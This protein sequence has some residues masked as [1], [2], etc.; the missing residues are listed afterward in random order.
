MSQNL[1]SSSN[2]SVQ[3]VREGL[4]RKIREKERELN[5]LKWQLRSLSS[6]TGSTPSNLSQ[7]NDGASPFGPIAGLQDGSV[8]SS[9]HSTLTMHREALEHV[10]MRD[11]S[12]QR[13]PAWKNNLEEIAPDSCSV[14]KVKAEHGNESWSLQV[15]IRTELDEFLAAVLAEMK[16]AG[17]PSEVLPRLHYIDDQGNVGPFP[18]DKEGYEEML[19]RYFQASDWK[20]LRPLRVVLLDGDE[21]LLGLVDIPPHKGCPEPMPWKQGKLLG[22]GAY[23][24]VYMG[25]KGDGTMIAVKRLNLESDH[26]KIVFESYANEYQLLQTLE[27]PNIVR[28]ISSKVVSPHL[29]VIWMEYVPGGSVANILQA[30]GN[31]SEDILRH[32]TRQILKGLSYLHSRDVI[33]RDVKP[34]NILVTVAGVVKLSDFGASLIVSSSVSKKPSARGPVGTAAYL[35]PELVRA[36]SP[37]DYSFNVDIWSLGI[38]AVEMLKAEMPFQDYSNH[39]AVLFHIGR[40]SAKPNTP[41]PPALP[42]G[43]RSLPHSLSRSLLLA[44]ALPYKVDTSRPSLRTNWTRL[45][46]AP[47]FSL[48]LSRARSVS[49]RSPLSGISQL[50]RDFLSRCL[51]P[52]P[53]TRPSAEDLLSHDFVAVDE[54]GDDAPDPPGALTPTEARAAPPHASPSRAPGAAAAPGGRAA[55][56]PPATDDEVPRAPRPRRARPAPRGFGRSLSSGSGRSSRMRARPRRAQRRRCPRRGGRRRSRARGSR[57]GARSRMESCQTWGWTKPR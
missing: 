9:P 6:E 17:P 51:E 13:A 19:Q 49:P 31:M 26:G 39:M 33:H 8:E 35:A 4:E 48:P 34:G 41:K 21:D 56:P 29:A 20:T 3:S 11:E 10:P 53:A 46:L 54:S 22:E 32:Y 7:G 37:A 43:A 12:Q 24:A 14:F 16:V 45:F 55:V 38:T 47:S 52:D 1:F 30:F 44:P 5:D 40:I 28:Y 15:D 42:Q 27:H 2:E 50:A 57:G 23:G 18:A 36:R 25:M